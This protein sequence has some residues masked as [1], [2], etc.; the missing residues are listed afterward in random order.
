LHAYIV[1]IHHLISDSLSACSTSATT[2]TVTTI[3]PETTITPTLTPP[4]VTITETPPEVTVTVTKTSVPT[5]IPTPSLTTAITPTRIWTPSSLTSRTNPA[6]L[7]E[8]VRADVDDWIDGKIVLELVVLELISGQQA[9][10]MIQEWNMFNDPPGAGKEYILAK[11]RVKI[12]EAENEPYDINSA[13][14]DVY[15]ATGVEYTE[16]F[17]VAGRDPQLDA[18]LFEGAEHVGYVA[19]LVRTDD[20]PVAVYKLYWDEGAMW[21]DLRAE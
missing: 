11:F 1:N 17:S 3:P 7:N 21:F 5:H 10:N 9:W 12:I 4:T 15:S 20:S 13:Q 2:I 19:F 16:F 14:F 18:N 8:V 6:E